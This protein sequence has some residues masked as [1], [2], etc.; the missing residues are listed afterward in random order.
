MRLSVIGCG[1]LG[2]VHAFYPSGIPLWVSD[3]LP[4][5]VHDLA[6]ARVWACCGGSWMPCCSGRSRRPII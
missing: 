2:A 5:N 6:A 3:V 1:H 4:G